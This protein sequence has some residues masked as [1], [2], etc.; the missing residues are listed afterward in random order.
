MVSVSCPATKVSCA[1]TVEVKTAGAIA[2]SSKTKTSKHK[3]KKAQLVL[4][5]GSFNLVGGHSGMVTIH[6][7]SSGL[8]ALSK[9]KHISALVIVSAHDSL[10]DPLT[11]T[12][13]L[14]LK[15]PSKKGSHAKKGKH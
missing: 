4:G 7:S 13:S 10:G 2:V 5:Q 8:S 12:L 15:A 1:G 3:S 6:L 14:A 9:L 11:A